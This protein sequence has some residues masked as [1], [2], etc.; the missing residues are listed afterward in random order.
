MFADWNLTLVIWRL[1]INVWCRYAGVWSLRFGDC[2]VNLAVH[3]CSFKL[4]VLI[5]TS[6]I[7]VEQVKL[8][9]WCLQLGVWN[10]K[11]TIV[12]FSVQHTSLSFWN[13]VFED[14]DSRFYV[15]GLKVGARSLKL[16]VRSLKLE[17]ES[18]GCVSIRS[19]KC[20][21]WSSQVEVLMMF[22]WSFK[23]GIWRLTSEVWS[24]QVEV[25]RRQFAAS[26]LKW[27][28]VGFKFDICWC[29]V[30][31]CKWTL[32]DDSLQPEV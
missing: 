22:G 16:A 6:A 21:L 24:L 5:W 9:V 31:V 3:S 7:E 19:L 26:I 18:L 2:A 25:W 10:L 11:I 4:M 20:N 8:D 23:L 28:A 14:S 29:S 32:E 1:R 15:E 13:G 27:S 30:E 17:I 12:L